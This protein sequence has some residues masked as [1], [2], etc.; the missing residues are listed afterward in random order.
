RTMVSAAVPVRTMSADPVCRVGRLWVG[1]VTVTVSVSMKKPI[2][3]RRWITRTAPATSSTVTPS[4]GPSRTTSVD[5]ASGSSRTTT[6]PT[7]T[8]MIRSR[9]SGPG[10]LWRS[11][12]GISSGPAGHPPRPTAAERERAQVDVDPHGP[13]GASGDG[14]ADGVDQPGVQRLPGLGRLL[15]GPVL[16]VLG[17]PQG[18]ADDVAVVDLLRRG[19]CRRGGRRGGCGCVGS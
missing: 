2:R 10:K 3:R 6:S 15:L 13:V 7:F 9:G 17:Q 8:S 14:V 19:G 12:M 11:V 16:E 5:V 18:E 1:A 4:V